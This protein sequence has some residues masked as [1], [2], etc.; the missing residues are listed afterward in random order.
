[1]NAPKG[2]LIAYSTSPGKTASD[3][4]GNNGLYTHSLLQ[5]IGSKTTTIM[6]M[7]QKVRMDVIRNSNNEQVPWES[8][9]LTDD[10]YF[11]Y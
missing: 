7:F 11:N 5:H 2:S 10:F 1:M 8:T 6:T 3:G 4:D 9:S